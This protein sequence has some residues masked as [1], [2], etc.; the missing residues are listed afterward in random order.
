MRVSVAETHEV[1]CNFDEES[2]CKMSAPVQI[3]A[4]STKQ[5]SEPCDRAC[6]AET[7][8][9]RYVLRVPCQ[10]LLQTARV[11]YDR[12]HCPLSQ[13]KGVEVS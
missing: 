9:A 3:L 11:R 6:M 13:A 10:I 4:A 2:H 8:H 7:P 12:A 1:A 5:S